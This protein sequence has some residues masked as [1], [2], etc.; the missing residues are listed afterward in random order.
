[1]NIGHINEFKRHERM[2]QQRQYDK[3]DY[4]VI[5]GIVLLMLAILTADILL[6]W[7]L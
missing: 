4:A 5:G 1:M 3:G 7:A 2:K 6:G